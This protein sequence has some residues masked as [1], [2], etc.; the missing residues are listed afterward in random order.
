MS[1]KVAINGLGRIGRAI[2]KLVIGR[3]ELELV[4]VN[5]L[6]DLENLAYLLRFDTV[7]GRYSKSVTVDGGQLVVDGRKL[8][9]LQNRDPAELPWKELGVDLVFECTGALKRR[10]DLEKHIQA[11]T[12]FVILSAPSQGG[13]VETV[14]HGAN[15]PKGTPNVISCASCTTN[16]IT[17]VV[18]IIGRRIGFKKAMMTTIHAY[19]SSQSIV[20]GPSKNFRR[21][22]AAAANLVPATTG[23]ALATTRALPEYGGLFDGIAIRAPLT[24]G[25]IADLTFLTSRSTS[26]EEVN[27]ILAEEAA[28]S[29]Y[30]GVLGVS[31]D[32]L[33]SADIVGDSRAS[34]VD[35]ELTKVV[36]GDLVKVMSWYDNEWGYANQMVR[37]AVAMTGGR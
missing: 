3:P 29:R 30:T 32:P 4:A 10:A 37:E 8:R 6:A 19:T 21:G 36:D 22:R 17:P 28:A 35:L 7:Y 9:T 15:V 12:R 5:D 26:V 27:R 31:N 16:C 14:V 34:V 33:V 20:D 24:V 2:L 1:T 25:S 18:E 11:G 13:E 23:A